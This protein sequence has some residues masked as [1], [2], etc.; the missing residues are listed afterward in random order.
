MI[1]YNL[2]EDIAKDLM[3]K[4]YALSHKDHTSLPFFYSGADNDFFYVYDC[5][6]FYLPSCENEKEEAWGVLLNPKDAA[7]KLIELLEESRRLLRKRLKETNFMI[8]EI[9]RGQ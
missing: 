9:Q 3:K 8:E 1:E 5:I 2:T 4:G 6:N 7:I